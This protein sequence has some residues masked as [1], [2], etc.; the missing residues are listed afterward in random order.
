MRRSLIL[1]ALTLSL[2]SPA[3]AVPMFGTALSENTTTSANSVF[4]GAPDD[5]VG[6]LALDRVIYDFGAS[7][8]ANVA[9]VDLNVYEF[10]SF[11]SEFALLDVLVSVDGTSFVSIK[12]TETTLVRI[13]GDAGHL[14]AFG[15]SYSLPAGV[16]N[17]RFVRLQGLGTG[18]TTGTIRVGFDLDAL[19]A[20]NVVTGQMVPEPTTLVLLG[21]G[22]L[23]AFLRYRRR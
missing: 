4:L 22:L 8:V 6:G 2:A 9:G 15:R 19:G 13:S 12:S 21:T 3:S 5:T 7:R 1:A 18:G 14:A 11:T 23:V 10:D 16:D 17:V 20:H